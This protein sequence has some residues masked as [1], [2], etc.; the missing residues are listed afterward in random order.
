MRFSDNVDV[1][2]ACAPLFACSGDDTLTGSDDAD[3]FVFS[4]P[5]GDDRIFS[6]DVAADKVDLIGYDGLGSFADVLAAT[7]D[8]AS[9]NAHLQLADGQSITFIGVHSADLTA[10]NFVFNETP[11]VENAGTMVIGN[12]AM[13]PLSG[14][15][16]NSGTISLEAAGAETLLQ[17]I[18]NG[19]TLQ[20]GGNVLLSDDIHNV[21][22]GTLPIVTLNNVDNV[23]SGAGQIGN[24]SLTLVNGGTISATGTNAL[25]I[26]T[27]ANAVVNSGTLEATGAGGL[28]IASDLVN[29][30][31]LL[32]NGGNISV[33]GIVTGSGSALISGGSALF[34]HDD[35]AINVTIAADASGSLVLS[36]SE[37]FSGTVTGF[38]SDDLLVFD[39]IL[40]GADTHV[41]YAAN[42]DGLGGLLTLTDGTHSAT[43]AM[44]GTFD[45]DGF[46]LASDGD[47]GTIVT[48]H[49]LGAAPVAPHDDFWLYISPR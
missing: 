24:G 13:L 44:T 26:D 18:Q 49:H 4:Q 9:G 45:A 3:T 10:A 20:G 31:Q 15:V 1:F 22:A 30:G 21:I 7:S 40:L 17:L 2:A 12:G 25:V 11:V 23:I 16:N 36:D 32:A 47:T 28:Y 46:E 38:D 43:I 29:D 14:T 37:H 27:G 34:L 6:F 8:D 41:S 42:A 33:G 39:D 35:A 19:V 5:I 48:Y